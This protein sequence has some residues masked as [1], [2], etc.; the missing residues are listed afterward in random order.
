[1]FDC[2]KD[3]AAIQYDD[4]LF[5]RI[6]LSAVSGLIHLVDAINSLPAEHLKL[7]KDL[8]QAAY[9]YY[10]TVASVLD[11]KSVGVVLS[12]I[13]EIARNRFDNGKQFQNSSDSSEYRL[14]QFFFIY[15]NHVFNYGEVLNN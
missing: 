2:T 3:C 11:D 10:Y 1:M 7:S 8:L 12:Y 9:C 15:G 14:R 6:E 5:S 4:C 13:Y